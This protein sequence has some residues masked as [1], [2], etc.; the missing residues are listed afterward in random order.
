MA[1]IRATGDS[2]QAIS[3]A[4]G[5]VTEM[6]SQIASASTQQPTASEDIANGME[7]IS[8]LAEQSMLSIRDVR[9][10][11]EELERVTAGLQ[12]IVKHFDSADAV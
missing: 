3:Q 12:T 8:G 7:Y 5:Q 9:Q 1:L 4:A 10:A 2:F 6:A 11:T